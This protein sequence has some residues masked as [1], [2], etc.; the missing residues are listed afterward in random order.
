[1]YVCGYGEYQ[2]TSII[3]Q[4]CTIVLSMRPL[5]GYFTSEEIL[6][7]RKKYY[8]IGKNRELFDPSKRNCN[9]DILESNYQSL[10]TR[11]ITISS[12]LLEGVFVPAIR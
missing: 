5:S 1:M 7:C 10:H 4:R 9:K 6:L 2:D 3:N 11:F 8:K 12:I